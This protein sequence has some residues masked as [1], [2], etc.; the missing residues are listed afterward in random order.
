M[1][2]PLLQLAGV[3]RRFDSP[4]NANPIFVLREISLSLEAGDTLAVIGPSGSGKSTLLHL[5][6]SLDRPTSGQVLF[7]GRDLNQLDDAQL[8]RVRNRRLGFVFQSHFLLPQCTVLENVLVPTLADC[9]PVKG[10]AGPAPEPA[11]GRARRLLAR[12]GLG[13]RLT[14]RPGQL[15]GGERQRVAV[16]RALINQPVLLLADEP[17][18]ALDHAAARSLGQLLIDL[19]REEGVALIIVTHALELARR[20]NRILKLQDGQLAPEARD[21]A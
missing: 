21:P 20:M 16:V 3:S 15:S 12:V 8:A 2:A 1:D 7:E 18:G 6:G 19:N 14:H 9:A 11:E 17:T 5:I 10:L 4:Q 13:E